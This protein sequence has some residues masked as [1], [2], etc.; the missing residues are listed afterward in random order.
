MRPLTK[1]SK[2]QHWKKKPCPYF[3]TRSEKMFAKVQCCQTPAVG[4]VLPISLTSSQVALLS[5]CPQRP[6]ATRLQVGSLQLAQV[7][8][9]TTALKHVNNQLCTFHRHHLLILV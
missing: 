5:P 6:Q 4:T 1:V 8:S 7:P 9:H 3:F 2:L